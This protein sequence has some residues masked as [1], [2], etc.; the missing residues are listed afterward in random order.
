[1]HF[2]LSSD[3]AT[4]ISKQHFYKLLGL[5]VSNELIHPDSVS[6]VD[7]INMCN[8]MGHDPLLETVSKMNKSRMPPRWNLLVS[9]IL[10]CFAERTTGSDNAS[11]LLLTLIYAIYTNSNI[12]I[13]H[14]LW[15]Q[16][17]ASPNSSS[18]T[19]NISMA[20]FWS[21]VVD[22]A[23]GKVR[24]LRGDDKTVMAEISEL[25]VNKLQFVKDRVFKHCGEIPIEMWSLVPED[26][27]QKKKIKKD[28]KGTLPEIVLREIPA[29]VQERIEAIATKK[30]QAKRKKGEVIE[31]KQ[32]QPEPEQSP[33]KKQKKIKK[34]ARKHAKK[35]KKTPTLQDEPSDDDEATQS[36]AS[37]HSEPDQTEPPPNQGEGTSK[38]PPRQTEKDTTFDNLENIVKLTQTPPVPPEQT[39]QE[40]NTNKPSPHQSESEPVDEEINMEG[41]GGDMFNPNQATSS[42]SV[43]PTDMF[44]FL[45]VT[46]EEEDLTTEQQELSATK[47]DIS[48]LRTMLNTILVGI[49]PSSITQKDDLAKKQTEEFKEIRKELLTSID[50]LQADFTSKISDVEKK[51]DEIT[52]TATIESELKAQMPAQELKMK[53]LVTQL[54]SKTH[55]AD[56]RQRVIDMYKAQNQE[57][58]LK[59]VKLVEDKDQQVLKFSEKV[60]SKFDQVRKAIS[61]IQIPKVVERVIEKII[62]KPQAT[63][64]E[65]GDKGDNREREQPQKT[66][67]E[68]T[69]TET[70]NKPPPKS[71]L[72]QSK[73][74]PTKKPDPKPKRPIQKGIKINPDVGSSRQKP[75]GPEDQ[76]RGKMI[77]VHTDPKA[78]HQQDT[79]KDE[80]LAK[81]LQEE[82]RQRVEVSKE[83]EEIQIE[84]SKTRIWPVWTRAKIMQVALAEPDPYWLHPI[85]SQNV[86]FDANYQLDMPIC[87]RAFLFKYMEILTFFTGNDEMLNKILIDFYSKKSKLQQDVWSCTPTKTI[88]RTRRTNLIGNAFYN[89]EFDITR[90]TEKVKSTFTFAELPLMNPSDWITIYQIMVL[91]HEDYCKPHI[92]VFKLLMQNYLFEMGRFDI[93]AADLMKQIPKKV[94]PTYYDYGLNSDGLVTNDPWGVVIKVTVNDIV[95]F[96]HLMMTDLY[97]LPPNHLRLVKQKVV[98]QN[99][100]SEH[101]KKEVLARIVWHEAMRSKII[102]FF[103]FMKEHEGEE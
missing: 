54:E 5:P 83:N 88:P 84:A 89:W 16:F 31:T 38:T 29:D 15:T 72:K 96:G 79:S 2:N 80:E 62:E 95:K 74:T 43:K 14:I 58:N 66:Q 67:P 65:G 71:P 98:A 39:E 51:I 76:G 91:K 75:K 100:N 82:E 20:R 61:E 57:M 42:T 13:G 53:E 50:T 70:T 22:G 45:P 60:D 93:V 52:K 64:Q 77:V 8:Q 41:P 23:L 81:K 26:E 49:D 33:P 32:V 37:H 68:K 6:N 27:P 97:T 101:D 9:I 21:I 25:Q 28:N 55:E 63:S 19:T 40:D 36:N 4:S 10:R 3:K 102:T 103:N 69:Q 12:D 7:L 17:C 18:R 30:P 35:P 86:K 1:M 85:A 59:H 46:F 94:E 92:K 34:P 87:P 24:E 11:K 47:K 44:T 78:T 56:H 90:G 99:R 48:S 73:K